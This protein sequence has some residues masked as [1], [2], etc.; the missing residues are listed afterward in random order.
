[1]SKM[2]IKLIV[3]GVA[4]L[5]GVIVL[6]SAFDVK[7]IKGYEVGVKE[8][9]WTGVHPDPL[10]PATYFVWPWERVQI[11][12]ASLQVF[13]MNDKPVGEVDQGRDEDSYLVQSADNQDMYFSLQVQWRIDPAHV[14]DLH[15]TIGPLNIEERALRPDLLKIVKNEGTMREA[16]EA[17]S[18]AGLVALQKDIEEALNDPEGGLRR[19]GI[20]VDSFVIEHIRLDPE[21]IAEITARQVAMQREKRAFQEEKAAL[22]M[23]KKAKAEAQAD[24]ETQVVEA[25]RDKQIAVLA[26]EAENQKE[27]LKAEA[28][29][30]RVVLAAEA[31]KESGELKAAA[32][33]AIGRATA[34][35]EKLKFL[36]FGAEGADTYARIQIAASMADAFGNIKGYLPENM[37]IF[38][39]GESFFKAVENAVGPN[40]APGLVR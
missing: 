31:E 3:A 40:D 17:Y 5:F 36:A 30:R 10:P 22:A 26:A 27:I 28:E 21:Y 25:E 1:M 8:D 38:T 35:A 23:A 24:Y 15:K 39:L 7:P 33:L 34:E 2:Q 29:K 13:V 9:F 18:G 37:Q 4:L 32:I 19:R 20:I 12:P 14:V 6:F 16:I 11:Y